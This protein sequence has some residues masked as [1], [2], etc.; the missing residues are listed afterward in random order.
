MI[1][2]NYEEGYQIYF[3]TNPKNGEKIW[4]PNNYCS[5]CAIKLRSVHRGDFDRLFAFTFPTF[6]RESQNHI[7]DCY[8]CLTDVKGYSLKW[9][10]SII[11]TNVP[12][13]T[14]AAYEHTDSIPGNPA[15]CKA[16]GINADGNQTLEYKPTRNLPELFDQKDL[17]Y[18]IR[19]LNLSKKK[20]EI[21]NSRLKE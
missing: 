21:L 5:N 10:N 6:C 4:I 1:S 2:A 13:V 16:E 17:N 18:L 3:Q 7:D 8:F 19:D 20:V 11:Y 14:K 12:S 15:K 9:K